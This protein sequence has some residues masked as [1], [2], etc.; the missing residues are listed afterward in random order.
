MPLSRGRSSSPGVTVSGSRRGQAADRPALPSATNTMT[1]PG[2]GKDAH[3]R[4]PSQGLAELC[5]ALGH[6]LVPDP[7][8]AGAA[9]PFTGH[10][11][12]G[13]E[14]A[15]GHLEAGRA[16]EAR[17]AVESVRQGA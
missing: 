2:G 8:P 17:G 15:L 3:V 13:V 6:W 5:A 9:V 16:E 1:R 12:A 10:H 11:A 4:P 14:E 7:P